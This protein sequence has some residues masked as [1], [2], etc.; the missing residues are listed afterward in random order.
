LLRGFYGVVVVVVVRVVRHCS[1]YLLVKLKL[2]VSHDGFTVSKEFSERERERREMERC[3]LVRRTKDA[4]IWISMRI[5]DRIRSFKRDPNENVLKLV[6]RLKKKFRDSVDVNLMKDEKEKLNC[7]I[8]TTSQALYVH[9]RDF[10]SCVCMYV[11]VC[12]CV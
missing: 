7:E 1:I 2:H 8:L 11:C 10:V 9:L 4:M 6:S 5:D 12:V 3:A